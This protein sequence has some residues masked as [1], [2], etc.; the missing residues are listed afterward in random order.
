M[1]TNRLFASAL[2][3]VLSILLLSSVAA[4]QGPQDAPSITA[5]LGTAITYQGR[6]L[7]GGSPADGLYDF[8]FRLFDAAT[9]GSQIG[10]TDTLEDVTVDNGLFTVK[11]DFGSDVFTGES[12]WL[13]IAVRPDGPDPFT[14]L[15][16]RQELT[17]APAALSLPG[18]WT[19]QNATSPNLIG[20]YFGNTVAAGV[21]GATIC[22]GGDSSYP[23]QVT[24]DYGTVGGGQGN[25]ASNW[26]TVGGGYGNTASGRISTIPGGWE[27]EASGRFSFAAGRRAKALHQGT[28]VWADSI[29]ADFASSAANQF[30]VRAGGGVKLETSGAGATIDGNAIW[31]AGNDG[32]A[33][34]LDADLLDG[35]Q[36]SFFLDWGN[37]TS[38]PAG[39]ADDVDNDVLGG[40]SCA[41]GQI[42]K[43]NGS[44]WT[45]AADDGAGTAWSLTGNAGTAP[46][47]HFLGTTD[48]VALELRVNSTRALR[49]EPHATS[50]N[51]IG[52]YLG[53]SVTAGVYG[54]TIGGGGGSSYLNSVT[55][56]Y[57]T[58]GGGRGNRA[59]DNAG[60]LL[61]AY[62]AT[63]G[64][65]SNNTAGGIYAVVGGGLSNAAN[66]Y[67]AFIG[68]GDDNTASGRYATVPGGRYNTAQGDYSF[69]AGW[70]AKALHAGSFVWA[71]ST[72]ADFASTAT[73]Q[74]LVRANG[75]VSFSTGAADF[76]VNGYVIWHAGND[77]AASGL[78]ADL[79][80]GQQGSFYQ[81][82][83]NIIVGMLDTARF[84]A[85]ADLNAEGF[86]NN[87]SDNDL[88]TR[89]QSDGRYVNEGQGNS[90]TSGMIVDGT[91]V[92]GDLQ[93]GATLAEILDDDGPGS[94]LNADLLDG[95]H[96]SYYQSRVS[97][98]CAVGSTIRAINADGTVVCQADAPLNRAAPPMDNGVVTVDSAGTVGGDNSATIGT[99]GLPL[100]SYS[101][102]G[103]LKV[104]HCEDI[105]CSSA[106]LSTLD[107]AG[108]VGRYTSV[109]IGADGLGVISYYDS[110]NGNLKVA[111][112]SNVECTGATINTVDSGGDV[113]L[114]TSVTIGSDGLPFVSYYDFTNQDLKAAHCNDLACSSASINTVESAGDVGKHTSV[115]I[116]SDGLPVISCYDDTNGD[117]L[118][119]HCMNVVCSSH[120]TTRVDS[121][122]DVGLGSSITIG[123]DGLPLI[124]YYD[125]TY[126]YE[127]LK[128]VHCNEPG[129]L[130]RTV[131]LLDSIG[132]NFGGVNTSVTIGADGLGLIIYVDYT[133]LR[134]KVAHCGDVA[135]TEATITT[136]E[137]GEYY[138]SV[139]VTI[140]VDGLP[141]IGYYH[142][143]PD[144]DLQVGHCANAFC[145]PYLRRR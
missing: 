79:L 11:L 58:V 10:S 2:V 102:G 77:G 100:F 23:N 128:V 137:E 7:E 98:S 53:N 47:T 95:Q 46:G 74:F 108:N 27:N 49:L 62:Y 126:G 124:S 26:S 111:H 68:G 56:H 114:Y 73:D 60:T 110:T 43:W 30:L 101:A 106:A 122:N 45:C 127:Y 91:I 42:A 40:L 55:D 29:D 93:D 133:S 44:A 21:I 14:P 125:N 12:R 82:A 63:V 139:S 113:G 90:V 18:L 145:A 15:S 132:E 37:L 94:G 138:G 65:G 31:H 1:K 41:S 135:C 52:G 87:N 38:V 140:G 4:A 103:D 35:Q 136:F 32:A 5:A 80:D 71:D 92:A 112:C 141:M 83:A 39:F 67:Y 78:D 88:L 86:L 119:I 19:Q 59:G 144:Y 50:P 96:G 121:T 9:G 75:G 134:L 51:L 129:C 16:P 81:D 105:D 89:A 115:T 48:N 84:S 69:A 36:G 64:G 66:G 3:L 142:E 123:V 25:S 120:M 85:Y 118:M 8:E 131:T 70:R 24:D 97:G 57:G 22:G 54:A 13:E 72:G 61:D 99:D 117:L 6:L 34:G 76:Q 116:G 143:Y 130:F 109:A 17:P 20:G 104:A 33:S 107:S 28:F